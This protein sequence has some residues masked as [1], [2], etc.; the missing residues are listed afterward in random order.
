MNLAYG[1]ML[2]FAALTTIRSVGASDTAKEER[3]VSGFDRIVLRGVG[4]LI[5]AQ[6]DREALV[7]EAER[8]LLP[9]ISTEVRQ[10]VLYFEFK[11]PQISTRFPIRY[12]LTVRNLAAI[13]SR[14]SGDIRIGRL[15]TSSLDIVL[16]GS[17]KVSI[18]RLNAVG[19][20]LRINGSADVTVGRGAVGVQTLAINGSGTYS[21]RQ[22]ESRQTS[23]TINGSGNAEVWADD[24]LVARI[25]G[26]GLVR[27][28]G[29]PKVD[30]SVTG[31]GSVERIGAR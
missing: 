11:E 8:R 29:S 21:A 25:P 7:V 20:T 5:I 6:S 12:M 4:E 26:S 23:V 14:A 9:Q 16:S 15:E 10:G 22:L 18:D 27:Y 17:G 30:A 2:F 3:Q 19:L 28:H 1:T 24:R 13:D 31:A